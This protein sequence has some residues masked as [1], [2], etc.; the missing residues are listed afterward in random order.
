MVRRSYSSNTSIWT[1]FAAFTGAIVWFLVVTFGIACMSAWL[2]M[3][4]L[5]NL[6]VLDAWWPAWGFW[7][8]FSFAVPASAALRFATNSTTASKSSSN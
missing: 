2:V 7:Q 6:H 3:L 8:V 5:G 1:A 4:T